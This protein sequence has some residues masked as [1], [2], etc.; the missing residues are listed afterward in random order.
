MKV[1]DGGMSDGDMS[2]KKKMKRVLRDVLETHQRNKE[3]K[4]LLQADIAAL[5]EHVFFFSR[6]EQL[7]T[8]NG[9]RVLQAYQEELEKRQQFFSKNWPET[10]PYEGYVHLK[11][12]HPN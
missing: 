6:S 2:D 3:H 4:K 12:F 9:R 8:A 11:D 10:L 1:E 5:K 7:A